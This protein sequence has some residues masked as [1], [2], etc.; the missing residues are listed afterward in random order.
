MY[1]NLR[2][3]SLCL[4]TRTRRQVK[5]ADQDL[6]LNAVDASLKTLLGLTK[7]LMT[8]VRELKEQQQTQ[9]QA[10]VGGGAAAAA[11]S[12]VVEQLPQ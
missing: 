3:L 6:K 10:A 9:T 12:S 2:T 7:E 4:R 11:P 5:L 8:E 1:L